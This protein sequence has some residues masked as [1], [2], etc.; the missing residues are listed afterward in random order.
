M[1]PKMALAGV[2][3]ELEHH[4]GLITIISEGEKK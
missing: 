4:L 2:P 1:Q 3:E